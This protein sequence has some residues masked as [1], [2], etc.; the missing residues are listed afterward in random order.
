MWLVSVVFVSDYLMNEQHNISH[1]ASRLLNISFVRVRYARMNGC[2]LSNELCTCIEHT[3]LSRLRRESLE[4][5]KDQM[6]YY[7]ISGPVAS[8]SQFTFLFSRHARDTS[9]G[10]FFDVEQVIYIL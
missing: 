2:F 6:A 9:R 3:K 1:L 8:Q 4:I 5:V 7:R 10:D